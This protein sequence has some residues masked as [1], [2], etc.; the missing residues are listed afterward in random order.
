MES[1]ESLS[2][3]PRKPIL[4]TASLSG[5]SVLYDGK[6]QFVLTSSFT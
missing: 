3:H 5:E 1:D 2:L 6:V 4:E